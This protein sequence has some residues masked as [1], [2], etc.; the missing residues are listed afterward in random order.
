MARDEALEFIRSFADRFVQFKGIQFQE[1]LLRRREKRYDLQLQENR[2]YR[3]RTLALS[4]R[5][6]AAYEAGRSQTNI[7][8][9]V[10]SPTQFEG[11][12]QTI[13]GIITEELDL[14]PVETSDF[15]GWG[16]GTDTIKQSAI[17]KARDNATR[18]TGRQ[19]F[20]A[21]KADQFDFDFDR[22]FNEKFYSSPKRTVKIIQ[23]TK[24]PEFP[25]GSESPEGLESIWGQLS[26]EEKTTAR[27]YIEGGGSPQ[28]IIK[29][30]Q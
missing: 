29:Q 18:R 17:D 7:N 21:G 2:R 30:L 3:Q 20:G 9:P 25:S 11:T 8:I 5:R 4:E 15:L 10:F 1:D 27:T 13:Q 6:T 23:D 24:E 12:G 28:D 26:D 16:K 14:I 22:Q 19:Y